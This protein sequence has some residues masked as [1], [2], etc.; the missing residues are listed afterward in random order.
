MLPLLNS[1]NKGTS[2]SKTLA[3]SP[4]GPPHGKDAVAKKKKKKQKK[5]KKKKR[6]STRGPPGALPPLSTAAAPGPPT[7]APTA[8]DGAPPPPPKKKTKTKKKV[9]NGRRFVDRM[10][11]AKRNAKAATDA[12]LRAR[13]GNLLGRKRKP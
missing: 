4:P 12:A 8:A 2:W 13:L 11:L 10:L 6:D 1:L 7:P 3:Q 5:K 9:E